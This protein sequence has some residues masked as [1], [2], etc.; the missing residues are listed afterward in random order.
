MLSLPSLAMK[1]F[2]VS[3]KASPLH[4][5]VSVFLTSAPG[6]EGVPHAI[7]FLQATAPV[8]N[9]MLFATYRFLMKFQQTRLD[10]DRSHDRDP[11]LYQ[12]FLAASGCGLVTTYVPK[13]FL[14]LEI[15]TEDTPFHPRKKG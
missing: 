7:L 8:L 9:G 4:W 6:W 3:T 1:V 11:T 14:S 15:K 13:I 2:V 5:S 10:D 12:V